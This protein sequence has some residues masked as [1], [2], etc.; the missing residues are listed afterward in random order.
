M[1][2]NQEFI[3]ACRVNNLSEV[4]HLLSEGADIHTSSDLAFH[5]AV[6]YGYLGVLKY[7]VKTD[8]EYIHRYG[9][10]ALYWAAKAGYLNIVK[11]LLQSG[12]DIHSGNDKALYA[13]LEKGHLLLL[14]F[15]L[16][17]MD[18]EYIQNKLRN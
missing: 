16:N 14:K 13:A 7:L 2:L 8:V 10:Y 9:H 17:Q 4:R 6:L 18:D 12:V 11:Y 1:N 15:L 5:I 3:L